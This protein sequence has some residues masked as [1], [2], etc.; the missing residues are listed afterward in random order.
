[1]FPACAQRSY[2]CLCSLYVTMFVCVCVYVWRVTGGDIGDIGRHLSSTP[3][4]LNEN[5]LEHNALGHLYACGST[6]HTFFFLVLLWMAIVYVRMYLSF[7]M[8]AGLSGNIIVKDK[9]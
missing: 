8:K 5:L 1:M 2:V 9:K 7:V 6:C 3:A 4:V